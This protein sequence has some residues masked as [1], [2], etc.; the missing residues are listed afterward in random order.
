MR[1]VQLRYK[2]WH[3]LPPTPQEYPVSAKPFTRE[4]RSITYARSGKKF[5]SDA[6][7]TFA[8][9]NERRVVTRITAFD[10][11]LARARSNAHAEANLLL[12][13]TSDA[14]KMRTAPPPPGLL[15]YVTPDHLEQLRSDGKFALRTAQREKRDGRAL[16]R[17]E[18]EAVKTRY[19]VV[20]WYSADEGYVTVRAEDRTPD[21][22]MAGDLSVDQVLRVKDDNGNEFFYP[23]RG[24]RRANGKQI[25]ST[26]VEV[27]RDSLIINRPVPAE[28]FQLSPLPNE[29]VFDVDTMKVIRK[30]LTQD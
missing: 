4:E 2:V 22:Q 28:R 26:R 25:G 6:V 20:L 17:V 15:S 21:G 3:E 10:G 9:E 7:S 24:V 1:T 29:K 30:R 8:N 18:V 16:V 13:G 27:E 23:G 12:Q 19:R 11:S 14:V 5:L